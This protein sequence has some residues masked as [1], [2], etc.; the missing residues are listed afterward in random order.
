MEPIFVKG[1][2][3]LGPF[4]YDRLVANI[5]KDYLRD[6]FEVCFWSG[7]RYVEVQRLYSHPEWIMKE[8]RTVHLPAEAQRKAKRA[9]IERYIL[10]I[11]HL[12]INFIF[13]SI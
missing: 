12:I 1:V 5:E 2:R 4:D 10:P 8:R 11:P 9:Q 3:I 6:I 13:Y 7:M